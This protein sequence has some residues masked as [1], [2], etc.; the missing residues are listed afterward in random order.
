MTGQARKFAAI[1][2]F[3]CAVGVGAASAQQANKNGSP[4]PP[5]DNIIDIEDP[6]AAY[7]NEQKLQQLNMLF[8]KS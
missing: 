4:P 3:V 5:R 1:L 7:L 6:H 8:E 2:L